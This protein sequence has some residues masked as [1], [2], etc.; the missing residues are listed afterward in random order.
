M[1]FE[2]RISDKTISFWSRIL[3]HIDDNYVKELVYEV[4]S[5][6]IYYRERDH[7]DDFD[8]ISEA[9]LDDRCFIFPFKPGDFI[10]KPY[11][12]GPEKIISITMSDASCYPI[13]NTERRYVE[14]HV[15]VIDNEIGYPEIDKYKKVDSLE[16]YGLYDQCGEE[17]DYYWE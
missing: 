1:S 10:Q 9:Y 16:T 12:N 13:I 8:E 3:D 17:V 4:F 15:V 14:E 11:G 6:F 2:D 5:E 7:F